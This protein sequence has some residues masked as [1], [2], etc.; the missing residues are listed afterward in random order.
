MLI[1]NGTGVL[2]TGESC[3]TLNSKASSISATNQRNVFEATQNEKSPLDADPDAVAL[4]LI[5]IG[6]VDAGKS[7]TAGHLVYL[8]GGINPRTIEKFEK[9]SAQM[10]RGTFKWAW[11]LDQSTA[12]RERGITIGLALNTIRT[13]HRLLTLI[14]AP[15]H[16]DF[17]KNMITGVS[18]ADIAMLV[19]AAGHRE[20]AAGFS[21]EGQTREHV[22]L[23]KSLG[24]GS[25]VVCVNKMDDPSVAFSQERFAELKTELLRFFT[26]TCGFAN[27]SDFPI[28]PISGFAG[29]NLA[30]LSSRMSWYKGPTVMDALDCCRPPP[31]AVSAPLRLPIQAA[32]L[33]HG[34]G[35]VAVGRIEAGKISRGTRLKIAPTG[36]EAV[37]RRLEVQGCEVEVASAGQIVALNL[38]LAEGSVND[39]RKGFILG[40][41]NLS[42]PSACVSFLATVLMLEVDREFTLKVGFQPV[43]DVHTAHVACRVERILYRID[44]ATGV[45][46][47]L[48]SE[49]EIAPGESCIVHFRPSRPLCVETLQSC[50][51]LARFSLRDK[52][53]TFA[54]GTIQEIM[55]VD[56]VK[57]PK[58]SEPTRRTASPAPRLKKTSH[59]SMSLPISEIVSECTLPVP[60]IQLPSSKIRLP[61]V[62]TP[63][64]EAP[65]GPGR[66][67]AEETNASLAACL[68]EQLLEIEALREIFQERLVLCSSRDA[69]DSGSLSHGGSDF[70]FTIRTA[71]PDLSLRFACGPL[72]PLVTA[73]RVWL[74]S[75]VGMDKPNRL[76]LE[77][78]LSVA[79]EE[80]R[81][82]GAP[83][84]FDIVRFAQDLRLKI[85]TQSDH[86]S[87]CLSTFLP[88]AE[89]KEAERSYKWNVEKLDEEFGGVFSQDDSDED[90]EDREWR[91]ASTSD[92][93]SPPTDPTPLVGSPGQIVQALQDSGE[94]VVTRIDNICRSDLR[95]RFE[96]LRS[97]FK[98]QLRLA[99]KVTI[100]FH[101][102]QD[103]N[104]T[105]IVREGLIVPGSRANAP[106]VRCGSSFGKGI[107]V[108]PEASFSLH[109]TDS[110]K[111]LLCAVLPGRSVTVTGRQSSKLKGDCAYICERNKKYSIYNDIINI[112]N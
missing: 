54:V 53:R 59:G 34:L 57:L 77:M 50:P 68:A 43:L 91:Q 29:D 10:H 39:L 78:A 85:E 13:K 6:H 106:T 105:S 26:E 52:R 32:F 22:L 2:Q 31:R 4:S 46:S 79:A 51:P 70:V 63:E 107:Y 18:Q 81:R 66:P 83:M 40:D 24:V 101:G 87:T 72:Y 84:V 21:N 14:D 98:N 35:L 27:P 45:R 15:G 97:Y 37:V 30:V 23:C 88:E 76:A 33:C 75:A 95:L 103:Q 61:E 8:G 110:H 44:R 25:L 41:A 71:N 48:T 67:I 69:I 82:K 65:A 104:L 1:L 9:E 19:V 56:E 94:I 62:E 89:T 93:S 99:D 90:D 5:V 96:R 86:K 42:P 60:K 80:P 20:F 7:T 55:L 3:S 17:I 11:V 112:N 12:E 102:T 38:T 108:S 16:R 64:V 47:R 111:L 100:A 36:K 49:C 58:Q 74:D 109:Y 28:I 73:P 92:F